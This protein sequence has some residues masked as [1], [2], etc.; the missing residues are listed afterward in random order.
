MRKC[1]SLLSPYNVSIELGILD[2]DGRNVKGL[3]KSQNLTITP[4]QESTL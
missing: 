1:P 4:M 2:L 3:W